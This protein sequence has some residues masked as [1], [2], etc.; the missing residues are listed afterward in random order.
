VATHNLGVGASV[1][2]AQA[3]VGALASQFDTRPAHGA[4]GLGLLAQHRSPAQ[5]LDILVAEDD[6]EDGDARDRQLGVVAANGTSATYSG[7][8]ALQADWAGSLQGEG[9]SVQGNGLAGPQVLARMRDAYL[10]AD[11]SLA[12]RLMTALE[13]GHVAGGQRIGAMSA[14][15]LV[16]TPQGGWTDVDLR[17]DAA[18]QPVQELR[19]LLDRRQAHETMLRAER[20]QRAHDT[21]GASRAALQALALS[22]DW[23]RIWRRAARLA[24]DQGDTHLAIARL[25]QLHRLNPIWTRTELNDPLY[26]P[27]TPDPR[28]ATWR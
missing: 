14:A 24:M 22:H 5:V 7:S 27:L 21:A 10:A 16:R 28:L 26:A 12:Q 15:L 8:H 23:D 19:G 6:G 3:R 9:F 11:G 25:A 2:Y 18:T 4:R 1:P 17:V 13:A 20:L